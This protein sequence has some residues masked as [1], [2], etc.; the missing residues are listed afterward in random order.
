MNN[1]DQQTL[2]SK[3][4]WRVDGI[5]E[6]INGHGRKGDYPLSFHFSLMA[7]LEK[8]EKSI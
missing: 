3:E 4:V 5:V 8:G 2:G 7:I 1:N 6:G